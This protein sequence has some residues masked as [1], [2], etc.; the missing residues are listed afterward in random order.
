MWGNG[1]ARH[2]TARKLKLSLPKHHIQIRRSVLKND[3]LE[4]VGV[5]AKRPSEFGVR[6]GRCK[7][8]DR[9][10]DEVHQQIGVRVR[11]QH[12][13]TLGRRKLALGDASQK[14]D[15]IVVTAPANVLMDLAQDSVVP[16]PILSEAN[17]VPV[18]A[19]L[20]YILRIRANVE[21]QGARE[22]V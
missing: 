19:S 12:P 8:P 11:K 17:P 3:A 7:S 22:Q 14:V 15:D 21:H 9:R 20:D 13:S 4:T 5:G 6:A 18:A 10:V 2:A 1:D 16:L